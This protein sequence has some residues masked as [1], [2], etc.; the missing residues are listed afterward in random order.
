MVQG[1]SVVW[2]PVTDI[3]RAV[4]FYSETLGLGVSQQEAQW[5]E[6]EAG[7]VKIGL[8]ARDEETP[9]GDGGAVIAFRPQGD[10]DG[11]VEQLRGKGVEFA[12]GVSDHPWGRVAT[13]KDPDGN[14]L[15]LYEPPQ[16]T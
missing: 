6:V 5:A 4:G 8:N 11:A 1:I 13:F 15:Q 3:G 12:G 9:G 16:T 7:D 10:I 14:D 2:L